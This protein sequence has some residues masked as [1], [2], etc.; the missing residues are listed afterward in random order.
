[1]IVVSDTSPISN[2]LQIGQL[3]LLKSLFE[4]VI[5]PSSVDNE[6]NNLINFGIDLT[7]CKSAQWIKSSN[8]RT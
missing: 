7:E 2:L 3:R 5:I 8:L 6:V 1:M 4:E